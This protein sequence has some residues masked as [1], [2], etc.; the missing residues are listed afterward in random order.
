MALSTL[1]KVIVSRWYK[2]LVDPR[3]PRLK[4][5][6]NIGTL[7]KPHRDNAQLEA[8]HLYQ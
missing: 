7:G 1:S 5:G 3:L 6:G 4:G 2:I 8:D